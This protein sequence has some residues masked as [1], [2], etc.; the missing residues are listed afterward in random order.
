MTVA[1]SFRAELIGLRDALAPFRGQGVATFHPVR[2][3]PSLG[4]ALVP[5]PREQEDR[6]ADRPRRMPGPRPRRS[7]VGRLCRLMA[8]AADAR[9]RAALGLVDGAESDASPKTPDV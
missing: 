6:D 7:E 9:R 8:A 1:R 3:R 2:V 5:K 4:F